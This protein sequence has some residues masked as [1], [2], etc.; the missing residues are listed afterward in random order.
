ML[1][2]E[3]TATLARVQEKLAQGQLPETE[4]LE[5]IML[6]IGGALLLTP[7]FI[8]DGLGFACL[9]PGLRRPI[10]RRIIRQGILKAANLSG[11]SFQAGQA[12][13]SAGTTIDGDFIEQDR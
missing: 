10:A 2:L 12:S 1:R 3:G 13:R 8:T 7:G 4:L 11:R 5:G 9:L 6:L